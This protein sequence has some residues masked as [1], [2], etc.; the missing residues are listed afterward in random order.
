[1]WCP[2]GSGMLVLWQKIIESS[3]VTFRKENINMK[4]NYFPAQN[5]KWPIYQKLLEKG[6]SA[7]FSILNCTETHLK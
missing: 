5:D 6:N 1:M 7:L 4:T 2:N 3:D